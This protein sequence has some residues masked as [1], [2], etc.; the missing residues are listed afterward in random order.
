MGR[1]AAAHCVLPA[2]ASCRAAFLHIGKTA[3][4]RLSVGAQGVAEPLSD[5]SGRELATSQKTAESQEKSM[6][7]AYLNHARKGT[8]LRKNCSNGY[9]PIGS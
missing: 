2:V 6:V 3:V 7:G 5:D 8:S 4:T 9:T 1:E